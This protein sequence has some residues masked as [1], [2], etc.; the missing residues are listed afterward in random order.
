MRNDPV[1]TIA[2]ILAIGL[3]IF[4]IYVI[5]PWYVVL[6]TTAVGATFDTAISRVLLGI[7]YITPAILTVV[8]AK[9]PRKW[10]AKYGTFGVALAYTFIAILRVITQ[11]FIPLIW[12]FPLICGL[13]TGICYLWV[14]LSG[15]E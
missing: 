10:Q 4:G 13:V 7:V 5:G 9:R 12:L 15:D 8:G 3:L 11:G 2:V 14:S 6:P 1:Y